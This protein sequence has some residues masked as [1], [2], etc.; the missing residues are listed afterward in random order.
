MIE[1]FNR[2]RHGARLGWLGLAAGLALLLGQG[3]IALAQQPQ[4]QPQPKRATTAAPAP[5]APAP[6][7][8]PLGVWIDHTGRGAVEILPCGPGLCG[9]IVW[10]QQPLDKTGQPLRD[11]L[12]ENRKLRD[13]LICGLQVIGNLQPMR[14][15]SWDGGWI[16]D[17]EQGESF[18][19]ELRLRSPDVLQ[20]K[21]YK[22]FKFLS[23]TF[24]WRRAAQMPQPACPAP[25]P[26]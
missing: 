17:P 18:D 23:E 5:A 14:D 20:V 13:R 22:G 9:R 12:N 2:T 7:P 15:G 11:K 19:V 16:Y 26:A 25:A 6:V 8:G 1:Q 24:Q 10:M 4:P 3:A 21:G